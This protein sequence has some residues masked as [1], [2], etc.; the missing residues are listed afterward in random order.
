MEEAQIDKIVSLA[1]E[2]TVPLSDTTVQ[3]GKEFSFE[4][5]LIGQPIPEIVW[6]KDGISILNNPDYLTTYVNGVC[7]L[8]IEETFAEDSAK[9]TCHAFNIH[10]SVETSAILTVKGNLIYIKFY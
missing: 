8:K 5:H 6:Y 4:C 7:I 2:F 10:G 9:Y 1:P 3:E